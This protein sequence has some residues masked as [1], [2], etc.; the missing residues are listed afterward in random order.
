MKNFKN[1]CDE[2]NVLKSK[3]E[4]GEYENVISFC[5]I[6][7]EKWKCADIEELGFYMGL[8]YCKAEAK[9][10]IEHG[11]IISTHIIRSRLIEPDR[12]N[13]VKLKNKK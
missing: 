9:K 2:C 5:D 6:L 1:I 12:V 3:W 10:K 8:E 13:K 11:E 7:I 4:K